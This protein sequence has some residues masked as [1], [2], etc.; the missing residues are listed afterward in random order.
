[1]KYP[2]IETGRLFLRRPDARDQ[3]LALRFVGTR[4]PRL[5]SAPLAGGQA[6]RQLATFLGH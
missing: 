4:R 3:D 6:W 5:A 2:L 1:M